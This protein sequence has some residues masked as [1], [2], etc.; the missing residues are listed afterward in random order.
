MLCQRQLRT[1]E[2]YAQE[3]K[4]LVTRTPPSIESFLNSCA[5]EGTSPDIMVYFQIS[6]NGCILSVSCCHS[7]LV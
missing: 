1:L 6:A 5:K 7:V 3:N 2:H 4:A